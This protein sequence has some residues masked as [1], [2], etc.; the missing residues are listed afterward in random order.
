PPQ[1]YAAPPQPPAGYYPPPGRPMM[2]P[3][4]R[5][6]G[7]L[8][9]LGCFGIGLGVLALLAGAIVAFVL[10]YK[11]VS[12]NITVGKSQG[13]GSG[14][15]PAEGGTF[16]VQNPA[17]PVDGLSIQV[18]EGAFPKG[19]TFKVSTQPIQDH[20]LGPLFN[21]AT[22]LI[23][24]D[25]GGRFAAEPLL[26]EIPVQLAE[27]D[28]AMAFYYDRH[29]GKLEGL[30]L[31]ALSR[32]RISI[33][34]SHFSGIVVSRIKINMLGEIT[35]DT[36]FMPGVDDWQF[37][38][39]GSVITPPGHCSGQSVTAM[40]YYTE[41]RLAGGER[42]LYGRFDNN[43]HV[44]G[45]IDL[46][47]DDSWGYRF[48]SVV[49]RDH[50]WSTYSR[51][52]FDWMGGLSD[53]Y[54]WYAFLY[55]MA[56][57]GEPQYVSIGHWYTDAQGNNRR[58][59]HAIVAYK[60]EGNRLYVA[61]PNYPGKADRYIVYEGG[62]LKPYSSG[63]DATDIA[64]HGT[65]PFEEIRYWAKSALVDYSH[66]AELYDQMLKGKVGDGVFPA[67]TLEYATAYDETTGEYTWTKVPEII[68]TDEA[69]TA[70]RPE[71]AGKLAFRLSFSQAAEAYQYRG[72][73]QEQAF[74]TSPQ[75]TIFFAVRLDKGDNDLGFHIAQRI[76]SIAED[77][78][79]R[80][81]K[82]VYGQQD[83]TGTWT[84]TYTIT[85]ADKARALI[86]QI[87]AQIIRAIKPDMSEA[88]ALAAAR[89]AITENPDKTA[90]MT[91]V[92]QPDP[93][94]RPDR[95]AAAITAIG[96]DG[97]TRH[98]RAQAV[99]RQGKLTFSFMDQSGV[100]M[101]FEGT[102][103]GPDRV[104]GTFGADWL[105]IRDLVEGEWEASRAP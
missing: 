58:V 18:P 65:V 7:G 46:Q 66:I 9:C 88:E 84:G 73:A 39:R 36:G 43:D 87:V 31:A 54:T 85:K 52:F 53:Q 5:R 57:T 96:T 81:V 75:N 14:K 76:N 79:F 97:D 99:V 93:N 64:A 63:A 28:F 69:T 25:N 68:E 94:G 32:D 23:S 35:V 10:L 38:N 40:W 86:E 77:L 13:A 78:D 89:E 90:Q 59:G 95:Y 51:R 56:V 92:L 1:Y 34:T 70:I 101:R 102:A 27:D 91:M 55:S 15:V 42:S 11:P 21:P 62:T 26:V 4:P 24:I 98:Y 103:A 71:L 104:V 22:P 44:P 37:V 60:I 49:Q 74:A 19:A 83:W 20:K 12:P 17:S 16:T 80:R 33:V 45:T 29:S 30:P 48:A 67:Y 41:K 2:A 82:V 47:E 61:D 6:G 8:S 50:N 3:P 72:T 105:L 100:T